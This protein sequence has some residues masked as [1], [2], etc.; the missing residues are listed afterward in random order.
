[1]A[2]RRSIATRI[3]RARWFATFGLGYSVYDTSNFTR[4]HVAGVD[5][6]HGTFSHSLR[7]SYLKFQNQ[8]TDATTGNTALPGSCSGLLIRSVTLFLGP[9]LLAPRVRRNRTIRSS[10]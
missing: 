8:I 2:L 6:S 7:F 5:W 9:S 4:Q 10:T 3:I 1:M